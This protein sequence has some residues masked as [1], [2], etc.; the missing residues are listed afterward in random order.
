MYIM[1]FSVVIVSV[2]YVYCNYSSIQ[3]WFCQTNV[4]DDNY[5]LISLWQKVCV[6]DSWYVNLTTET[7]TRHHPHPLKS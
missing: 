4:N 1:R 2:G 6:H 7:H 5:V 3:C